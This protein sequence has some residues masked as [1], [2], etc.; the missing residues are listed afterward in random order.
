MKRELEQ[1]ILTIVFAVVVCFIFLS[2]FMN[3][4]LFP[5]NNK[6]VSMSPSIPSGS[7]EFVSPLFRTPNRGDIMLLNSVQKPAM[8]IP[9]RLLNTFAGFFTAQH[10]FPFTSTGSVSG[11]PMIRRVAA[12]PGDTIYM[13]NYILHVRPRGS[14]NYL[15]EFEVTD[16]KYSVSISSTPDG[17]DGEMGVAG[18]T[19]PY[20]LGKDEYFVLGDNRMQC[21]DSRLWGTVSSS[22]F[23]GKVVLLY[24]PFKNFTWFRNRSR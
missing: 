4:I 24:F 6:S 7:V 2:L 12:I 13:E 20:T 10:Y 1:R 21:A 14:Q 23:K 18:K 22:Q 3:F 15:S 8:H 19:N 9:A 16:M 5:V 11:T 17:W